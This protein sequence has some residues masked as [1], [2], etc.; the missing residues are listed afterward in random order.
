MNRIQLRF[1]FLNFPFVCQTISVCLKARSQDPFLRIRFLLVS[2]IGSCERIENDFPTHGFV[3][4]K[5]TN[6]NRTCSIFIR[7]SLERLKAPT[8]FA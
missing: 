3:I 8:N 4:L 6:G 2:K 1:V 5:K 7:H